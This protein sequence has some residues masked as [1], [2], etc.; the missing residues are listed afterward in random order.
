[1]VSSPMASGSTKMGLTSRVT[2][3]Q[4]SQREK[5]RGHSLMETRS[6]ASIPKP[7]VQMLKAM[8]SNFRGELLVTFLTEHMLK[9]DFPPTLTLCQMYVC[10]IYS[11]FFK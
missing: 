5:E 7:N 3:D 4:T 2:L 11:L 6:P 1:M 9:L 8:R 10:I